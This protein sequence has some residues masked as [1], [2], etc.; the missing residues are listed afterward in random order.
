MISNDKY[1]TYRS[2]GLGLDV[3]GDRLGNAG[4]NLGR[5]GSK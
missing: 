3:F 2:S 4:G 5:H 1:R